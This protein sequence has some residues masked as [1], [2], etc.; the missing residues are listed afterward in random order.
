MSRHDEYKEVFTALVSDVKKN[1]VEHI[2]IAGDVFHTKV[3]GISPEYIDFMTWW[4]TAMA[5]VAE[6]HM[7]LG[8]HDGNLCNSSRQDAVSPVVSALN[9]PRI[10]LYKKSGVYEFSPGYT[11]CVFSLFDK[12]GW[13][14]VKPVPGKINIACFHGSVHGAKTDADWFVEGDLTVEFFKEFEFVF[15]GDIHRTQFLDYRSVEIEIDEKDL[16]K[17]P[18]AEVVDDG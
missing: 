9:N 5:D 8:N 10:H 3:S 4:L 7:I 6:V 13:A 11:W 14:S 1:K 2:F 17:Y 15:L 18:G 12:E 16:H